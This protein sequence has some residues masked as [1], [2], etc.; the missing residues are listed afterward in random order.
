MAGLFRAFLEDRR[1]AT[2]IEYGLMVGL[3]SIAAIPIY[4]A[5]GGS[6]GAIFTASAGHMLKAATGN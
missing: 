4:H 2:V 6:L 3:M 1:G 5:L